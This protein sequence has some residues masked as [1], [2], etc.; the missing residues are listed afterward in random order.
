MKTG[1]RLS[2]A[3]AKAADYNED[4]KILPTD[5]VRIKNYIMNKK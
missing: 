3:Y 5:Y 4:G 2:G 1:A